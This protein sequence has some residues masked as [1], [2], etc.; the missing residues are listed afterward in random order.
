MKIKICIVILLLSASLNAQKK[1]PSESIKG[2]WFVGKR[3][4]LVRN[5]RFIVLKKDSTWKPIENESGI[6]YFF[7]NPIENNENVFYSWATNKVKRK[8]IVDKEKNDTVAKVIQVIKMELR[9]NGKLKLTIS[10]PAAK[11]QSDPGDYWIKYDDPHYGKTEF[12][13]QRLKE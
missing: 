8:I 5:D 3:G 13:F 10:R 6:Y 9:K 11:S 4:I 12:T 7:D 1:E 2:I